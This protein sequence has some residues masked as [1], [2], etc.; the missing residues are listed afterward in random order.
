MYFQ[1]P[2]QLCGKLASNPPIK[3]VG[4]TCGECYPLR[5]FFFLQ[6]MDKAKTYWEE[7]TASFTGITDPDSLH[8]LKRPQNVFSSPI[9]IKSKPCSTKIVSVWS[10]STHQQNV[11]ILGQF[12][13]EATRERFAGYQKK[14]TMAPL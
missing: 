6:L 5:S 2:E 3:H 12:N 1:S 9:A 7:S 13:L 11:L 10:R 14:F 4:N 8:F